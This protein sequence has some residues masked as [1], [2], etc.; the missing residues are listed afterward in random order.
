MG[1]PNNKIV[2]GTAY[3]WELL[4]ANHLDQSFWSTNQKYWAAVRSNSLHSFLKV[5][6]CVHV[7]Q[8][9]QATWIWCRKTN[10]LSWIW[11]HFDFYPINFTVWSH[12]LSRVETVLHYLHNSGTY[13]PCWAYLI[14]LITIGLG[15][16]DISEW[17]N[18]IIC[19]FERKNPFW[20]KWDSFGFKI[21]TYL[22]FKPNYVTSF[23]I[24]TSL[25]LSTHQHWSEKAN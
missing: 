6:N 2:T 1:N 12:I 9:R 15:L 25:F 3:S 23:L 7:L 14:Y 17:E 21:H 19:L 4:I 22:I 11:A 24:R 18:P 13:D 5:H 20:K 8:P 10:F 16:Q